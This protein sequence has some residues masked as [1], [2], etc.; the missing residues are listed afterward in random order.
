MFYSTILTIFLSCSVTFHHFWPSFPA[1]ISG[2]VPQRP[3]M[4]H[5]VV[6]LFRP[7]LDHSGVHVASGQERGA[8]GLMKYQQLQSSS[9]LK[10]I[11]SQEIRR[12]IHRRNPCSQLFEGTNHRLPKKFRWFKMVQ[13][14]STYLR[15]TI[16]QSLLL[17]I[18]I[19]LLI[20]LHLPGEGL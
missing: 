8:R 2:H 17:H 1:I 18:I 13:A 16:P 6:I 19:I 3:L 9:I 11:G 14:H 4:F 7:H 20:I 15:S 5:P 12:E 10:P